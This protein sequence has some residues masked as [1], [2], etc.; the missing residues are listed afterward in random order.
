MKGLALGLLLLLAGKMMLAESNPVPFVNQPLVPSAVA[1]A[2]PSFTLTVNGTGFVSGSAVNWN[3]TALSTTFVSDSQLTATVPASNI[4][5]PST[6]S[7]TVS[8]PA[9]GGGTS[10]VV[11]FAVAVPETSAQFAIVNSNSNGVV[12]NFQTP[13]VGD[14]TGNGKLDFV[15]NWT[16]G[17][18][19][20]IIYTFLGNNN[21]TF[22]PLV[23]DGSDLE[24]F[25]A[26][27][28]NGDGILDLV[29]TTGQ[30]LSF[31]FNILTGNGNGTFSQF[32]TGY[33]FPPDQY[34]EQA[35]AIGDFNGDGKLDVALPV[36]NGN[37]TNGG[38]YVFLGNGDGTF[39]SPV[40]S[41]TGS[42]LQNIAFLGGVGD[43]NRDGKLD[44]IGISGTQL[45][46]L[47]GNGDGTFQAPSTFYPVQ[48]GGQNGTIVAA[49]LNGDDKLD[50][51]T[52][53]Y[54]PTNTFTV[55]LGNGDGTFTVQPPYPISGSINGA[56]AIGDFY[57]NGKLDLVVSSFLVPGNGDGT[58]QSPI[59]LP[60]SAFLNAAGD[61]N[62][63]GRLDL[64][65]SSESDLEG[66][67]YLLQNV[68]VASLS[69]ATSLDLGT[70]LIGTTST[71]KSVM[72]SNLG[73][74]PLNVSSISIAGANPGDFSFHSLC[75]STLA[76][77]A[78]CQINVTFTPTAAGP[79]S[80]TLTVS[81]NGVGSPTSVTLIGA[82][83]DFSLTATYSTVSVSP[84]GTAVYA[85]NITPVSGFNQPVTLACSGTPAQSTCSVSPS[86]I[87]LNG[88]SAST[89]TVTVTTTGSAVGMTQ[90][91]GGLPMGP[92]MFGSWLASWG[93][94][95]LVMMVTSVVALRRDLRQQLAVC[96]FTLL[97]LLAVGTTMP[98]CGGG[99]SSHSNGGGTPA[100]SY[101]LTVTG[102]FTS[103][104]TTL[105]HVTKLTL[106]VQ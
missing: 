15:T 70:Q 9:P 72:L 103:S 34:P 97:L 50:L 62:N 81:S 58:F 20:Y 75:S 46:F 26:G 76:V 90:P 91:F 52:L 66:P 35:V 13:I 100:G 92:S 23:S 4:A 48:A 61:F 43:F 19:S 11:W 104:S 82:A 77:N 73:T 30:I 98:A 42:F 83:Q 16:I 105:S 85:L 64:V 87:T 79:R 55:L 18:D 45:A 78:S 93:T 44:L 101:T 56:A 32:G 37:A 80:A 68:P 27:D 39:R 65:V 74:A 25:A 40:I 67:V 6:A 106:I 8:S 60:T 28:F 53:Q 94:L 3:G 102:T 69:P 36:T 29:G 33:S 7:I 96:G 89:A 17:S 49:D 47:Q 31:S 88:S 12:P 99:S 22:Q 59:A 86:S 41:N 21:G 71:A 38:V 54:P 14:F 84:G 5:T 95:G 63:D 24:F 10:N 51:I 2:G 57:A 1:P